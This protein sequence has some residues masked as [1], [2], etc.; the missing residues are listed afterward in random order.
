MIK[1][2]KEYIA[3]QNSINLNGLNNILNSKHKK[4]QKQKK[5]A[6]EMEKRCRN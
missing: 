5:M 4:E 1:T 6:T 2:N 3:Y